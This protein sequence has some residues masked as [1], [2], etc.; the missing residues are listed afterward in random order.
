MLDSGAFSAWTK[1]TKVDLDGYIDFIL[2]NDGCFDYIV[3]LDVIPSY[4]GAHKITSL[5]QEE[6]ATQGWINYLHMVERG[7]SSDHLIHV[8]HMG[9][10][11]KWLKKA[12]NKMDFIGLAPA[13]D[14]RT[15][16]KIRW[17]NE[18]MDY[19]CKNG[20][21]II[22]FHG[23]GVTSTD[24]LHRYPWYS[25][26]SSSWVTFSRYGTIL[27]PYAK[28]NGDWNYRKPPHSIHITRRSP[29]RKEDS[30]KHYDNMPAEMKTVVMQYVT[31][32][33]LKIGKSYM[34]NGKEIVV[35]EGVASNHRQR[36]LLNLMY[37][38][39]A[40]KS[41]NVEFYI[42]G[43]FPQMKDP[44]LEKECFYLVCKNNDNIYN[45]LVSFWFKQDAETIIKVKG[46]L[47]NGNNEKE[48]K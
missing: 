30:L 28:A 10:S 13:K 2:E 19:V 7:V 40:A 26:D 35:R 48:D 33:G 27:I 20:E 39:D 41:A 11:F 37:Y 1:Q 21:P 34:Q 32:R 36:D 38:I 29:S 16:E 47:N 6:A 9:E 3:G 14:V 17:L 23:F 18:C 31:S 5:E 44:E 4:V 45:R 43:N 42:S 25:V 46:E 15:P 12:M 8:F 24:I 22:K